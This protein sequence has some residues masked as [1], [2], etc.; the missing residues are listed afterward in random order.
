MNFMK[1]FLSRGLSLLV[2]GSLLL[3]AVPASAA[4][5]GW[6]SPSSSTNN[7]GVT[8]PNN[9]FS[10][11]NSY[12]V[13]NDQNDQVDYSGF[14]L[15]VP[16]GATVNGIELSFEAN[17]PDPRTVTF[18]L[19]TNGTT[20]TSG[21]GAKNSG[22]VAAS[23][24]V[25]TLG[26]A[27]DLWNRSWV[28]SD[29]SNL[30]VRVDAQTT[31]P[32]DI[33]NLDHFQVKVY[34]T[35][36]VSSQ[37]ITFGAL[38]NKTYGDTDFTVSATASSGLTVSFASQTTG[39]CTTSGT[40]GATVHIVSAG[41]CTVR[42]SQAGNGSYSAAPNVDQS[43]TVNKATPTLSIT[44]SPVTYNGLAQSA[45]VS[46]SV[47]GT[48]SDVKYGGSSTVPTGAGTYAVTADFTP[49]DTVN[50]NTL[51]DVSS[52]NFVITKADS[53]TTITCE[54]VTYNG[55]AQTPCT[56]SV[57]GA[58]GLSLTP[59]PVYADNT[60][61]GTASASYNYAGDDNHN[62]SSDS[63]DFTIAKADA[64]CSVSGY[65]ET[66][67]ASMHGAS[68]ACLGVG[69]DG[70][71]SGLDLGDSFVNVPGG[72]ASW[73]FTDESGNYN[74]QNGT[75]E[76]V[77]SQ[78]SLTA[79]A[80]GVSK[81]YDENTDAEVVLGSED[82]I[83]GD[84]VTFSYTSAYFDDA[85]TG[86]DK[87]VT[88]EGIAI[89]GNDAGNYVLASDTAETT[90]NISPVAASVSLS[91]DTDV[92][93]DGNSHTL[94]ASTDP[95]D[96][97][98][99]VLYNGL[100]TAPVNAGTYTVRALITDENY[101][102]QTQTTLTINPRS[103]TVAADPEQGKVYGEED[104]MLTYTVTGEVGL[105]EGDELSGALTREQ[106]ESAGE[107]DIL[108]GTLDNAHNHNYDISFEGDVFTI[109]KAEQVITFAELSDKT[110]GDADFD[111]S[112]TTNA[113]EEGQVTFSVQEGSMCELT[114]EGMS[115]VHLLGVGTCTITAYAEE[116]ENYL[117]AEPVTRSFDIANR[118]YTVHVSTGENGSITPAGEEGSVGVAE[119]NS[120][121]FTITPNF[122][123]KVEDVLV[124]EVSVGAVETFT[125]TEVSAGHTISATFKKR[126]SISGSVSGGRVLG[127]F[128]DNSGNTGSTEGQV[129]GETKF[130]FTLDMKP[131]RP[132]NVAKY[133]DEVMELQKFLNNAGFGPLV[134][135]GKFGAK[136]KAALIK[137]QL[138]N[139]LVGDG[140]VGPLTRAVLNK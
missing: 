55:Y 92:E 66:Y 10:S 71:L 136:T 74:D 116:T 104:P 132:Y 39:V 88:V 100:T 17:R 6:G 19:S 76:I 18:S 69:E 29:I 96:L 59:E 130:I 109:E 107:Y 57:T 54:D 86:A 115:T 85:D 11:N 123:Y 46:G 49:N 128:N 43:F 121:T 120:Q 47:A 24:T 72:T 87:N 32:G 125:F 4:D 77:I 133:G 70:E 60:D 27:A 90:A 106:G 8:N 38:S 40:N 129:L 119:G 13:F 84:D 53:T 63:A 108:Q 80:T 99:V 102:G 98:V 50:Y 75:V 67:D 103:I 1:N 26:G 135:D 33:L 110:N 97:N 14:G 138:A 62:S 137:F 9:A 61:A 25:Y 101:A 56:V 140:I 82:I 114:G 93:Y 81:I 35:P 64:E 78:K 12:A 58:G 22:N 118:V 2:L 16:V 122:G 113:G 30:R 127:A 23:D 52:G 94:E 5:T 37:T 139:G 45:T 112:A 91:G 131:G 31:G 65:A 111:I 28:V 73:S 89:S 7:N 126:P 105:V 134:V 41:T 42:A 51:N 95:E 124:D 20:W 21:S 83:E 36:A 79:V 48:V 117:E 3:G 44:N 15:S 68:G 34:Y